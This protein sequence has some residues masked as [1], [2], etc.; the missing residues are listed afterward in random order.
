MTRVHVR[1]IAPTT[2]H[3][4]ETLAAIAEDLRTLARP[5]VDLSHVQI[6]DG[7]RS[8][9]TSEDEA[10]AL[11]GVLRRVLEARREG[12]HAVVL[13]CTSDVGLAEARALVDVPVIGPGEAMRERTRGR[14]VVRL[15]A[16]VLASDPL[17]AALRGIQEGAQVV[18][19][20]G[21]GWSHVAESLR[22]QLRQR[23]HQTEV[24]DPLPVA[25]EKAM[26]LVHS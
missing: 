22:Q 26:E 7:P 12:V 20:G 21:T 9:R 11:P 4:P 25:L 15:D 19:L 16:D 3:R 6:E 23:G 13:D 5:D 18:V 14:T 8:V 10:R 24:L 17:N 2:D 1:L